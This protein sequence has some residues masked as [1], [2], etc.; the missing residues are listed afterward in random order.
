[1]EDAWFSTHEHPGMWR[2]DILNLCQTDD[3]PNISCH[4]A[5]IFIFAN[6]ERVK[7]CV[8]FIIKE[9]LAKWSDQILFD[10]LYKWWYFNEEVLFNNLIVLN[11]SKYH[12]KN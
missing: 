9:H 12:V 5:N 8:L 6:S 1:M 2:T 11:T 4:V 7:I 10:K 3:W